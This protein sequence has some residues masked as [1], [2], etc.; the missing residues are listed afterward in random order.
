M[1][2]AL[3]GQWFAVGYVAVASMLVSFVTGRVL[4]A[5]GFADFSYV[6]SIVSIYLM[7]MEGGFRALV[8]REE[9]RESGDGPAA[10]EMAGMAVG[11]V[12]V[13][14]ACGCVLV[15]LV[16]LMHKAAVAAGLA[17]MA[18]S[19]LSDIASS[20]IKGRG[21]FLRDAL[22]QV[23]ARTFSAA[24]M[25]AGLF[26]GGGRLVWIFVGGA[27][28][29]LPPM[30]YPFL[31][32]ILPRPSFAFSV[33]LYRRVLL[34]LAIDA[35]TQV[36]LRSDIV[37]LKYLSGD[38]AQ[39]GYYAAAARLLAGGILLL[40][41]VGAV[42]F[43]RLRVIEDRAAFFRLLWPYVGVMTAAG[44]A[45]AVLLFLLAG[46]VV[47]L[48]FGA[49]Y[50]P[51]AGMLAGLGGAFLFMF[52]NTIL[53]QAAIAINREGGYAMAVVLG[54]LFNVAGNF[55]LIPAHGPYGAVMTTVATE[56]LL[57]GGMLFM[58]VREHVRGGRA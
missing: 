40:S 19:A 39:V 58:L 17:F 45:A 36:Y 50:A 34:F 14:F 27:A 37:V 54:A 3:T 49:E 44:V 5:G 32:G 21:V 7:V 13:A 51:A 52:P 41:P 47:S 35:A 57:F 28:G 33:I 12:L 29:L 4:G 23:G 2:K 22:W 16:P 6:T 43:R 38:A 55:L 56:F 8:F 15:L 24:G 10:G 20:R 31:A 53:T 18:L 1:L 48:T 11:H 25:L 26:L 30:V 42:F 9:A 46:P